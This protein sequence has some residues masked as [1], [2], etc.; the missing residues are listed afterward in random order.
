MG[1]LTRMREIS[2]Y[3]LVAFVLMFVVFMVASDSNLDT[4]IH[5]NGNPATA[6]L[7]TVN[8]EKILYAD[9]EARLKEQ[10]EFQR[11]GK[12]NT[13][14]DEEYLRQGIWDQMVQEILVR[15]EL[16]NAGMN[17]TDG[18]LNDLL[19]ENTPQEL[20]K[21]YTDSSGKFYRDVFIRRMTNPD[22]YADEIRD[23][24]QKKQLPPSV[25]PDSE[26]VKFKKGIIRI[27]DYFRKKLMTDN[28]TGLVGVAGSLVSPVYVEQK[29]AIDNSAADVNYLFFDA[30]VI[31]N[32][33]VKVSDE[34][35]GA[36]YDKYKQ[37]YKQK[38]ARK[39]KYVALAIEPAERDSASLNKK[40]RQLQDSM[41][42]YP[43][44]QQRDSLYELSYL[45]LGGKT[46]DFAAV[47]T[48]DPDKRALFEN[49]EP[50]T[51]VGPVTMFNGTFFYRLDSVRSG[52]NDLVKARHVL[53][54]FGTNK[55]SARAI[56]DGLLRRAKKGDDFG[57]LAAEF[58][59]DKGS[60]TRGGEYDFFPRGRM[61]KEF[62]EAC[63]NNP[64]GSIVGPVETQ[65][66]FHI[67][68][69]EDKN[70]TEIKY[71]EI[72]ISI[73]VSKATKKEI[74][75]NTLS[76]KQQV[77]NGTPIDTVA[78]RMK[79]NTVETALFDET[80][81][82]LGSRGLTAFAFENPVGAVCDPKEVKNYGFVV[83]QVSDTRE[84]GAKPLADVKEEIKDKL[85]QIKK[86]KSLEGKAKDLFAKLQ[87][88]DILARVSEIDP[89]MQ[90]RTAAGVRDNGV[91]M[92][93][94]NDPY[95]TAAAFK[96]P[97]GKIHGPVRGDRGYYIIQV[98]NRTAADK[99]QLEA[100][101]TSIAA[102]L[103]A[104]A[105]NQAF[106]QWLAGAKEAAKIEDN[107]NKFF[108]D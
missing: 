58:S 23:A 106:Y 28:L 50:R 82:I 26:L 62:E 18:E 73:N 51:V 5:D 102:Q 70:S 92:G 2:P 49:A 7:G 74:Q 54:N 78:K 65:Y 43:S 38:P 16:E 39:I 3:M 36:Y 75:R 48:L 86:V 21:D 11:Q 55:D 12:L 94:G 20:R 77:E 89:S 107:R 47:K 95:F 27:E 60:A 103:Q 42:K 72:E 56:A 84:A 30:G 91:V 22:S 101:S 35:I 17:V 97:V 24:L 85:L 108:R 34:E 99:S 31:D 76:L 9:F 10:L 88:K 87:G 14:V 6:A 40:I 63:F 90:V 81:P 4:I 93:V 57:K 41:A 59:Q 61:V 83:A 68:K 98:T 1:V 15:Q 8:G 13:E 37:Y 105:K 25:D 67:I 29:F 33:T 52:V 45:S 96:A 69:V 19:L 53:I 66:G 104:G 100:Q 80:M 64:P 46:N 32:K 79:K 44:L 71:S